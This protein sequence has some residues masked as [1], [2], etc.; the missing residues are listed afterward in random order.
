MDKEIRA[1][2]KRDKEETEAW[3]KAWSGKG[4]CLKNE[5]IKMWDAGLKKYGLKWSLRE[6]EL[7]NE[8]KEI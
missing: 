3:L 2:I 7:Q 5:S 4:T 8:S 6:Y 1:F